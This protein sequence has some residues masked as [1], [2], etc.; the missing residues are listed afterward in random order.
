MAKFVENLLR[1]AFVVLVISKTHETAIND[2]ETTLPPG[3]TSTST[4]M[5]PPTTPSTTT[6]P[7]T[8]T[9]GAVTTSTG[10]PITTTTPKPDT[11]PQVVNW[12]WTDND[13]KITCVLIEMALK[14]NISY[15]NK[16]NKIEYATY[17]I[18]ANSQVIKG[19]CDND[20]QDIV[21]AFGN[22]VA[23]PSILE[24]DFGKNS[25]AKNYNLTS[26][27]FSLNV[28]DLL[29]NAKVNQTKT[30]TFA[31][32]IFL[33]PLDMSY[34]CTKPQSLNLTTMG[35]TQKDHLI[36]SK[37]QMEAFHKTNKATF[38]YSKDCEA[39]D[40]PDIVPIAV[41]CALVTLIVIVLIA[42]LVGRRRSQA[43]GYLSM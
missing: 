8:T 3:T 7:E 25:T 10:A 26:I 34:H 32:P 37:V 24:L 6:A 27:K 33:T 14:L 39:I 18:P 28:S 21:V 5:E 22:N 43:R 31:G 1:L 20:T 23:Y 35:T 19:S 4:T 30:L 38:S 36:V 11:P 9:T 15:E 13:K 12:T 2:S 42:Y 41:G 16:D 17:N 29:P 40:T